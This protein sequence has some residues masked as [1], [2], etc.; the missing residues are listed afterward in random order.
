MRKGEV[1]RFE[2]GEKALA[3][4]FFRGFESGLALALPTLPTLPPFFSPLHSVWLPWLGQ[5]KGGGGGCGRE[6][7]FVI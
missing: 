4:I 5:K 2:A 3:S 7:G 1:Q 6:G